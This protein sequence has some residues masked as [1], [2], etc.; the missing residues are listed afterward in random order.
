M[1]WVLYQ[2]R[3]GPQRLRRASIRVLGRE[4][5]AVWG[6]TQQCGARESSLH[7]RLNPRLVKEPSSP[8]LLPVVK[9]QGR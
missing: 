2:D 8:R 5:S 6:G 4:H 7:G 9:H 3:C 1:L